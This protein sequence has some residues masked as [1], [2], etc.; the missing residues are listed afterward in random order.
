MLKA[1][2]R[3]CAGRGD[4]RVRVGKELGAD[5]CGGGRVREM[6]RRLTHV[7]VG[8]GHEGE[9]EVEGVAD[10]AVGGAGR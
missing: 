1:R 10:G 6:G 3:T 4:Q 7:G 2:S 9:Q 5:W 8:L